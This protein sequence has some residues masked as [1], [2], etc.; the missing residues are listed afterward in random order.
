[1]MTAAEHLGR[2]L[3]ELAEQGHAT[4]CQ[5]R[6]RDRWT[7]DSAED[8]EWA[9]S[10][11]LT[12]GC[13][14][15]EQCAAA[16]DERDE[17][18][19]VWGARDRTPPPASRRYSVTS[20]RTTSSDEQRDEDAGGVGVDHPYGLDLSEAKA[21]AAERSTRATESDE[22]HREHREPTTTPS[23]RRRGRRPRLMA[24]S[25]PPPLAQS[26][27]CAPTP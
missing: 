7:S 10:V 1:M 11:C 13:P 27:F 14:V 12:L 19:H 5:G 6:R 2:A 15:L 24:A 17:R 22:S 21:T 18:H 20:R 9:A 8:R 26:R 4:P 16:A 3:L 23:E 25:L